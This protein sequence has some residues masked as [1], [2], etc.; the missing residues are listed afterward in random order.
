MRGLALTDVDH[1]L[2]EGPLVD[3]AGT[4]IIDRSLRVDEHRLR[5]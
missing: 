2:V 1:L 4:D 5:R 3:I